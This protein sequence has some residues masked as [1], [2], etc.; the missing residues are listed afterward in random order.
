MPP[1]DAVLI[2]TSFNTHGQPL[3][4]EAAEALRLLK[5]ERDLDYVVIENWIFSKDAMQ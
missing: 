5:V 1:P 4:N 3:L 2:N